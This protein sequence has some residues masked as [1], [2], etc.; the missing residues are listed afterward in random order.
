MM[1]IMEWRSCLDLVTKIAGALEVVEEH[2]AQEKQVLCDVN[3]EAAMY[4]Q[5]RE[6]SHT[7]IC[8]QLAGWLSGASWS[9]LPGSEK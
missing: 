1:M 5:H 3:E 6:G 8:I 4:I 2:Q 9:R 7:D